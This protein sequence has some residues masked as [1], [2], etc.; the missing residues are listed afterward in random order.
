[1]EDQ[2]KIYI[3]THMKNVDYY[4]KSV[5]VLELEATDTPVLYEDK[6]YIRPGNDLE[7]ITSFKGIVAINEQFKKSRI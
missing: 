7:E 5:I 3:T 2:V 4:G 1:M 6:L